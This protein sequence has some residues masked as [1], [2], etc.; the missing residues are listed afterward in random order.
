MTKMIDAGVL[1]VAYEE[2]GAPKGWP[3]V[4]LH[5]FPYDIRAYDEVVPPPG[6][7]R[8]PRARALPARLRAD[9]LSARATRRAPASRR[10]SA[11]TCWSCWT[12]WASRARCWSATTGAAAPPASWRRCGPSA[13]AGWSPR[14]ATTSRTSRSP[15]A[16]R[17]AGAEHRLWYQYYFHTERGRAGLARE[18]RRLRAAC[19]GGCGRPTGTSTTRPSSAPRRPSTIPTS[20]T[21]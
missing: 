12:R 19:C 1:A 3:V 4:L 11:T 16:A 20:S 14:A 15:P 8:L 5:G 2:S 18:P 10:R 9:A 6:R 7:G 17:R 13:C 21:W